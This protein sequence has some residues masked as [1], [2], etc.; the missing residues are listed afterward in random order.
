MTIFTQESIEYIEIPF[1]IKRHPK[2]I[3]EILESRIRE[4]LFARKI[5]NE[6]T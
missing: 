1:Y 5:K 2:C 4:F 6:E 3:D